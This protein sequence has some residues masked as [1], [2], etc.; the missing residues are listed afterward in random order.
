M[1]TEWE[2]VKFVCL[3]KKYNEARNVH[4]ADTNRMHGGSFLL[5]LWAVSVLLVQ[6]SF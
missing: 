5:F 1:N 2:S 4:N 6:P 3:Y